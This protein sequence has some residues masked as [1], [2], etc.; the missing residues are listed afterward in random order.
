MSDGQEPK[1][2]LPQPGFG[3]FEPMKPY[4][5]DDFQMELRQNQNDLE[6]TIEYAWFRDDNDNR[7]EGRSPKRVKKIILK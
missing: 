7:Y 4:A 1:R 6:R 3:Y 2:D 5:F